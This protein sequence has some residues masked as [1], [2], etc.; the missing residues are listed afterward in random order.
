MF[1]IV[2]VFGV[3]YRLV[4]VGVSGTHG[5]TP[6]MHL[7]K[8]VIPGTACKRR[9]K[10]GTTSDPRVKLGM[11]RAVAGEG[12]ANEPC[13]S[14]RG[15]WGYGQRDYGSSKARHYGKGKGK[16]KWRYVWHGQG[17]AYQLDIAKAVEPPTE[18]QRK[19]LA[20][21]NAIQLT[22]AAAIAQKEAFGDTLGGNYINDPSVLM[23]S[24]QLSQGSGHYGSTDMQALVN[25]CMAAQS[26]GVFATPWP[27]DQPAAAQLQ[28]YQA[29]S[30]SSQNAMFEA[31]GAMA[32]TSEIPTMQQT[33]LPQAASFS[34]QNAQPEA[35]GAMAWMPEIPTMQRTELPQAASFS[36]QNALP[37][38]QGAMAWTPE[39]PTMQQTELPKAMPPFPLCLAAEPEGPL[40]TWADLLPYGDFQDW[41]LA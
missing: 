2:G 22:A 41:L 34:S 36:S 24:Q 13:Q 10:L 23:Q 1:S 38:A 8:T 20:R 11:A 7:L 25:S 37:E 18:E 29:A 12:G 5:D 32:W 40:T 33:E 17:D 30:L 27:M 16:G 26:E 35:Q 6:K 19:E 28:N 15:Q 39:M 4:S 31:P 14:S 9:R 21:M 3:R